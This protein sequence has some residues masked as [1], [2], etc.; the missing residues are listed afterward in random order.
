MRA[1]VGA[2]DPRQTRSTAEH[3]TRAE[4][5]F[6]IYGSV[7]S[8]ARYDDPGAGGDGASEQVTNR[9]L[10]RLALRSSEMKVASSSIACAMSR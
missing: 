9:T 1:E 5:I 3:A 6:G 4:R 10:Y 7:R 2:V 8:F